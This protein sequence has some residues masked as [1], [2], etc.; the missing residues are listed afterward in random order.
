VI[1]MDVNYD[2]LNASDALRGLKLARKFIVQMEQRILSIAQ[3]PKTPF[4][5]AF[6]FFSFILMQ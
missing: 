5:L 4:Y 2:S 3:L 6:S 1:A